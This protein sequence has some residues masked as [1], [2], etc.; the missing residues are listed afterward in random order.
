M[1]LKY[2]EQLGNS[3]SVVSTNSNTSRQFSCSRQRCTCCRLM[4]TLLFLKRY[5][6]ICACSFRAAKDSKRKKK[7]ARRMFQQF[8][9]SSGKYLIIKLKFVKG[10]QL[11]NIHYCQLILLQIIVTA[12]TT[13]VQFYKTRTHKVNTLVYA[14]PCELTCKL[15]KNRFTTIIIKFTH[16]SP[17]PMLNN[18]LLTLHSKKSK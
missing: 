3:H 10:F 16:H 1:K 12:V 13:L 14:G 18:T 15:C 5:M 7:I 6:T 2:I 9:P 8:K 17:V 4:P 11:P